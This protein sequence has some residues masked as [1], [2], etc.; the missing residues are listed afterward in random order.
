MKRGDVDSISL[1]Y[2]RKKW[3]G[4]RCLV[5]ENRK[6]TVRGFRSPS[7]LPYEIWIRGPW[8]MG[9]GMNVKDISFLLQP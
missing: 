6:E 5:S 4:S 9:H 2:M 8:A 1:I 3:R 7:H